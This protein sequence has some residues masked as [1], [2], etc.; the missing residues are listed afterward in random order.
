MLLNGQCRPI[1]TSGLT[2][3]GVVPPR[4]NDLDIFED[5]IDPENIIQNFWTPNFLRIIGGT[6]TANTRWPWMVSIKD[7]ETKEHFCGG[8]IVNSRFILT[9]AHCFKNF[10]NIQEK[11][12]EIHTNVEKLDDESRTI[13]TGSDA[14]SEENRVSFSSYIFLSK[15][16][17]NHP[18]YDQ[19]GFNFDAALILLQ[20]HIPFNHPQFYQKVLPICL[21]S[22]EMLKGQLYNLKNQTEDYTH[23]WSTGYGK[24]SNSDSSITSNDLMQIRLPFVKNDL[25]KAIYD[26]YSTYEITEN[27][28]CAGPQG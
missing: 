28:I 11:T 3:C 24:Y 5:E 2:R 7:G 8:S 16:V 12:F 25:C 14:F 21:E 27:M 13:Y 6:K 10:E 20:Q 19:R 1:P 4:Y 26:K 15:E 17:R 9:A 22:K 23:F 18:Q